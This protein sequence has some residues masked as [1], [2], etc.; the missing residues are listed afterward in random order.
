MRIVGG[1]R[2]WWPLLMLAIAS[3]LGGC[4][5]LQ[6]ILGTGTT[7]LAPLREGESSLPFCL[8]AKPITYS[9]RRDSP[10]TIEQ[11]REHN[12]VGTA[13]KCLPWTTKSGTN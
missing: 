2:I 7:P 12:A 8:A 4:S 11:I 1:R 13:L 6:A 10:E 3:G 5:T 9:A